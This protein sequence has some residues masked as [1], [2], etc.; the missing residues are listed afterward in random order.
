MSMMSFAERG[1]KLLA[2]WESEGEVR[3][4]Q[5]EGGKL[6]QVITPERGEAGRKYPSVSIDE[7]G[8]VLLAWAEGT[9][10]RRGGTLAY[11]L[12]NASGKPVGL[13]RRIDRGIPVFGL[14]ATAPL[15]GGGFLL[16]H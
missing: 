2:A 3:V 8:A 15:P 16:V 10:F 11:Q 5:I 12:F 9:A 7:S 6:G 1:D 13:V 14:P 4:G